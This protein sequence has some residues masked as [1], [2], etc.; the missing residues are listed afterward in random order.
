MNMRQLKVS[1]SL[2][3]TS[4]VLFAILFELGWGRQTSDIGSY[5]L[6]SI[7]LLSSKNPYSIESMRLLGGELL[8]VHNYNPT[9]V[10]PWSLTLLSPLGFL[11]YD[12][13]T[14]LILLLNLISLLLGVRILLYCFADSLHIKRSDSSWRWFVIYSSWMT[15]WYFPVWY[16]LW[17]GQVTC[18]LFLGIALLLWG[19]VGNFSNERR[20]Y[21]ALLQ[22]AGLLLTIMKAHILSVFYLVLLLQWLRKRAYV[23]V[24]V[25]A[26]SFVFA[27]LAPWVLY[28]DIYSFYISIP[29]S[30]FLSWTTP[31]LSGYFA[32]DGFAK[33]LPLLVAVVVTL[34]VEFSR[35]SITKE[36]EVFALMTALCVSLIV[37]PY[38]WPYDYLI[39]LPVCCYLTGYVLSNDGLRGWSKIA[40]ISVLPALTV[41]AIAISTFRVSGFIIIPL[42]LIFLSLALRYLKRPI[43]LKQC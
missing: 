38:C 42:A 35:K 27:L 24:A 29:R 14:A 8:N 36:D 15:F 11:S 13:A 34:F 39:L 25:G 33:F 32:L 22:G 5:W 41:L 43:M 17:L 18:F 10:V 28:S 20:I 1:L 21:L 30:A 3:L 37:S 26:L 31:N 4:F 12:Y 19:E 16:T 9:M 6:S 40:R 7:L 2:L 23:K